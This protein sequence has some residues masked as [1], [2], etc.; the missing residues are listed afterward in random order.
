VKKSSHHRFEYPRFGEGLIERGL[1]EREAL[2]HVV[3]QCNQA[4]GLLPEI[5]VYES[6]VS[7][8]EVSRVACE[9]YHLPFLTVE[10][11]PPS[12]DAVELFDAAYLH[13]FALVPLDRIGDLVTVVMPG[14]VPSEALEGLRSATKQMQRMHILPVVGS[15]VSN[16]NWLNTNLPRPAG[17]GAPGDGLGLEVGGVDQ[18]WVNIFDAAE[19][20]VQND[21]RTKNG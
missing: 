15:V 2:N 11:Y 18:N 6:F 7:D 17:A 14:L 4:H 16:R 12:S 10:I 3:A 5:L 19:E 9:L 1:I 21:L 13:R 8:W 20:A